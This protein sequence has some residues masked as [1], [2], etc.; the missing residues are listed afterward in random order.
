[1]IDKVDEIELRLLVM[2][3]NKNLS[4]FKKSKNLTRSKMS[5][6]GKSKR[7]NFGKANFF[8][9]GFSYSYSQKYL[10]DL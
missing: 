6:L 8:H 2:E 9:N 10:K 1:M 7:V 3:G 5:N 4:N